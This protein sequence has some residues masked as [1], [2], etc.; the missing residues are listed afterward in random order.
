MTQLRGSTK[1]TVP[2]PAATAWL[3][4]LAGPPLRTLSL[5]AAPSG[6][7]LGRHEQADIKLPND[8]VSRHHARFDFDNGE[9][10]LTDLSSRWGTFLNG[11]R[12]AADHAVPLHSGDMVRISPWTFNFSA[13]G[14]PAARSFD[15]LNDQDRNQTFIRTISPKRGA[16]SLADELLALLLETTAALHGAEDETALAAALLD[17]A[18]RG[19]K[20]PNAAV[21]KPLDSEGRITVLASRQSFP[22]QPTFSR[23]LINV[24]STGVVASFTPS[25]ADDISQ[26][27]VSLKIDAALCIPLMLGGTV[28]GYLYLDG[29]GGGYAV[30][31]QQWAS[32]SAFCLALG[33]VA[34]LALSNLKRLDVERRTAQLEADFRAA[35][36]AQRFLLPRRELTVGALRCAGQSQP[37]R[38][39]GGDFFDLIALDNGKLA[40]ALGDVSGKGLPAAILM[41]AAHGFLH[42]AL[43]EHGQPDA[44]VTQLNRFLCPRLSAEKFLT[45]WVG[46]IDPA[47][48]TLHYV[49]AGHGYGYLLSESTAPQRLDAGDNL[50]IGVTPDF[51][52]RAITLPLPPTGQI[53]V[54]SDGIVEQ[55]SATTE[56]Q[57]GETAL[58]AT[59]PTL[60][61]SPDPVSALLAAVTTHAATPTLSDD[62]TAISIRW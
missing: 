21:L 17:A 44:A 28:A 33:H 61:Q 15:T 50:P 62:A 3:I 7:V 13:G 20:L 6:L 47:A 60:L 31:P 54:V 36:E 5:T 30:S 57:F 32:A 8:A 34:S 52:A 46:V 35:A 22:G 43:L 49:D 2:S 16:A 11:V 38:H 12:I 27:I 9:W 19:T 23:S 4:P 41:T 56:S 55:P 29:R 58:P 48:R 45:L 40:I 25:G 10:R 37:G 24:A 18:M 51:T 39:V 53:L 59:L 42:A 26:S 1:S 14:T